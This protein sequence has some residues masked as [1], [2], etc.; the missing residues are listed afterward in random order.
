MSFGKKNYF[1]RFQTLLIF[2]NLNGTAKR[3]VGIIGILVLW[4]NLEKL[5]WVF[6]SI[7]LANGF[8]FRRIVVVFWEGL[9]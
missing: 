9:K 1:S 8:L 4:T 3:N 6:A 7:S 2:L 5:L